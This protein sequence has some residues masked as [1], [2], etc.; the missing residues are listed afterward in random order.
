MAAAQALFPTLGCP[1]VTNL[2]CF[3]SITLALAILAAA[4]EAIAPPIEW[5]V[6]F[7]KTNF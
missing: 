1:K 7:T 6:I 4:I 5:P 3:A 2:I